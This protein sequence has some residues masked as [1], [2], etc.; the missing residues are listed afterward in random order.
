MDLVALQDRARRLVG[1]TDLRDIRLF[2]LNLDHQA[3]PTPDG[4][5][6]F[7]DFDLRLTVSEWAS[8]EP[9]E[10]VAFVLHLTTNVVEAS[11]EG[12]PR[13]LVRTFIAYGGLYGLNDEVRDATR[14]EL[15]GF[16]ILIA[17]MAVWPYMRGT[18]A[19]ALRDMDLHGDLVLP[20]L[21]PRE[22]ADAIVIVTG[23]DEVD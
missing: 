10:T 11:D 15:E 2:G 8:D 19:S 21:T 5:A 7:G 13:E 16:G 9:R 23:D 20:I 1:H 6:Q 18:L 14:D 22:L 12:D 3:F 17:C 4:H